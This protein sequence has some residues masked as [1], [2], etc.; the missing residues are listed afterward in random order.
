MKE[1]IVSNS[2]NNLVE[3]PNR[4]KCEVMY[5]GEY[6]F[7]LI[8]ILTTVQ[9]NKTQGTTTIKRQLKELIRCEVFSYS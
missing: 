5:F 8:V 3:D 6:F 1:V 4:W 9:E 2:A 7:G